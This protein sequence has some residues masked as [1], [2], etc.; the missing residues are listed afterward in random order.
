MLSPWPMTRSTAHSPRSPTFECA[1]KILSLASRPIVGG[2]AARS[3]QAAS[4]KGV[5]STSE[6][7]TTM[8]AAVPVR[9]GNTVAGP[10]LVPPGLWTVSVMAF[11]HLTPAPSPDATCSKEGPARRHVRICRG[12][13]A[14][15]RCREAHEA[16]AH[17]AQTLRQRRPSSPSVRRLT[18]R[19]PTTHLPHAARRRSLLAP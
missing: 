9:P 4:R 1:S 7:I 5:R 18:P 11:P 19:R 3:L 15:E 2:L 12:R 10:E 6:R 16:T 13:G 14:G 8:S 17:G